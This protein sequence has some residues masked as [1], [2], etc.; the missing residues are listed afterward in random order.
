MLLNTLLVPVTGIEDPWSLILNLS[1]R[2][3]FQW[4]EVLGKSLM[5]QQFFYLKFIIQL[6]FISNGF[7]LMDF[8]HR[9]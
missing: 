7:W 2:K 4:N 8:F 3:P 9:F 1:A 6:T 5:G